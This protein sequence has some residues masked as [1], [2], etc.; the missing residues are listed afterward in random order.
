M[1]N[2]TVYFTSV[3][4][5]SARVEADDYEEAIDS[6]W[7]EMPGSLCHQCAHWIEF[8]GEWEPDIVIDAETGDTVWEAK[9]R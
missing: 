5:A 1:S 7:D 9:K 3:A 4:S 2:Y 8:S 6:A